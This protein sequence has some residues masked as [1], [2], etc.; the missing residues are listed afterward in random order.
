MAMVMRMLQVA[1]IQ[2]WACQPV[3]CVSI[4]RKV[5]IANHDIHI[6]FAQTPDQYA[7]RKR[8]NSL[9]VSK[10]KKQGKRTKTLNIPS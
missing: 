4:D 8:S 5:Q 6:L 7:N 1:T 2:D 10:T 3:E 9:V